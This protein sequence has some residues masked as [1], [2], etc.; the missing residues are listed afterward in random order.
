MILFLVL[1]KFTGI[2]IEISD[3]FNQQIVLQMQSPESWDTITQN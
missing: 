3:V 1:V 2:F